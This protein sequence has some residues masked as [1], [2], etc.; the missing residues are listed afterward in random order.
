MK[1]VAILLLTFRE[2]W[3]K[4]IVIG[5]FAVC[6]FVWVMLAFALNLD[7][8]EGS[9]AG[10][11]I[12]GQEATPGDVAV[13]PE[14]GERVRQIFTL[15]RV[16]IEV[17]KAVAA[18]AYWAG[19]ILAL[20]ATASLLPSL[21][22]HGHV[23]L[24]LS[25]PI[26]RSTVLAGHLLGV[27]T[28]MVL[29]AGYLF[30]MVWLVMSLKSGVWHPHFFKGMIIVVCMFGAMY[31]VV[32]FIGVTARNAPLALIVSYGLIIASLILAAREKLVP[33]INPPWRQVFLGFYYLLPAFGEVTGTVL[34]LT[35]NE[36]VGSL[37]P[38]FSSLL[39]G[40]FFL[41][42]A[43]YFLSRRDF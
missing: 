10:I 15:E 16:V 18:I 2:M 39:F 8:V 19:I 33:Q 43:F 4:K 37:Y 22:A 28:T 11:R 3:A 13:D 20:F 6:T 34:K 29:L 30:G 24:L 9:L 31:S 17:E 5:L 7:I 36:P 14:T 35:S 32:A 38:L 23:D 25:K 41:V 27:L 1:I 12:F 40:A 21:L 26:R 42:A